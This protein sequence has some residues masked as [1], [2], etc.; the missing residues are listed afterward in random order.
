[1]KPELLASI[2]RSAGRRVVVIGEAMLDTYLD[3]RAGRL[4]REAPAPI[5]AV[6]SRKPNSNPAARI[7]RCTG[8]S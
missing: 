8:A 3:G 6:E 1:M 2:E 7:L 5:V 4:C